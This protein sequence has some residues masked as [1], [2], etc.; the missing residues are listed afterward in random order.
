MFFHIADDFPD[1]V[2]CEN[3]G[4]VKFRGSV[5]GKIPNQA[6]KYLENKPLCFQLEGGGVLDINPGQ[7]L[8]HPADFKVSR[9]TLVGDLFRVAFNLIQLDIG[10]N[11]LHMLFQNMLFK[12][13]FQLFY[14]Q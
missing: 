13:S 3:V 1:S 4:G 2:S 14:P 9:K 6:G 11:F 7:G 5:D 12:S 10:E 8:H